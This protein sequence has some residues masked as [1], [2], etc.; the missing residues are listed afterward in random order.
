[1]TTVAID[2][3]RNRL[4]RRFS[5]TPLNPE[6]AA[7]VVAYVIDAEATGRASHGLQRVVP[8]LAQ[9]AGS[10]HPPRP[11]IREVSPGVWAIEADSAPG[12]VAAQRAV[13][14]LISVPIPRPGIVAATGFT[15]TTGAL[16][17]FTAQA[18]RAGYLCVAMVCCEAGV[19]PAGGIDPILGS[20]PIAVSFPM[21]GD[22]VTID[23]STSTVSYGTLQ[24]LARLGQPAPPG[25]VIDHDG[26]PSSDP[27]AADDGAQLPM[28]G[29][30]GYGIGL[31]IELL[32]GPMIGAK[33][34]RSAVPGGDGFLMIATPVDLFRD[35]GIV[36]DDAQRLLDE[37]RHSRPAHD[38]SPVRIPGER[39]AAARAAAFHQGD[40]D[41]DAEVWQNFLSAGESSHS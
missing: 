10:R 17:Y 39:A 26:R 41:I 9:L 32:A 19:A 6:D 18:A 7:A 24:M 12:L 37:I 22:P 14:I 11:R 30:K 40:V 1:V 5:G 33:A 4:I 31:L 16:G 36:A 3:L 8:L 38:G 23:I 27:R 35:A 25:A 15:G 13:D 2:E 28:A 34:G 29:H 20:N 21:P